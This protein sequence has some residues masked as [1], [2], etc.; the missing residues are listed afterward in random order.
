MSILKK[1]LAACAFALAC[2]AV[3]AAPQTY[4]V[5]IDTSALAGQEG[6]LDFLFLGLSNATPAQALLSN[7]AGDFSAHS[8]ALGQAAGAIDSL[9]AIGNG[10]AWNEFGQWARLGGTL[11]FDVRLD[12]TA[13]DGAGTTLS[14]ALLDANLGYLGTAG[15]V[16]TFALQPGGETVVD[17]DSAYATVSAV[18]EPATYAMLAAGLLLT[19]GARTRRRL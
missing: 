2:G 6:Y 4:H 19:A 8:F 13:A 7:F 18:P 17:A 1:L 14:V 10:G 15:D 3:Q 5:S 12:S 9:L 16:A 11:S